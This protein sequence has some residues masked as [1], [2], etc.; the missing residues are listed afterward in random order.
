MMAGANPYS[1]LDPADERSV[2]A[3]L[4]RYATA[5]DTRD[6]S[7]LR[8]CF[9]EDVELDLGRFGRWRGPREIT[10]YMRDLHAG[11]GPTLHRISNISVRKEAG[12]IRARSYV[13]AILAPG[14]DG[15]PVQRGV[16]WYDDQFV[17]TSEGWKITRRT[18]HPVVLE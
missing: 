7:L 14:S 9:A 2:S 13:D 10:A 18:F 12:E 16:G 11:H 3:V 5:I 6:W 15:G 4:I 8:T 17:R 1:G